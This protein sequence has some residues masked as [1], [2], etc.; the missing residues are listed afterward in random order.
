VCARVWSPMPQRPRPAMS[1]VEASDATA[2]PHG[3][4]PVLVS[5]VIPTYN[6]AA[7]VTEQ[8]RALRAQDYDGPVE[9]I[10]ADNGSTDDLP[11]VVAGAREQGMRIRIADASDRRG[12]SHARNVGCREAAG[13]LI[14]I[15]DAD[16]VVDSGWLSALVVTAQ[17]AAV[18]GGSIDGAL[19][20][21]SSVQQWRKAY[22]P[23]RLPVKLGFLPYAVG[24]NL[25]VWTEVVDAVAGWDE[26]LVGG[27]D[28]VD[29]SWRVQLAG[30]PLAVAPRA[31]VRYRHRERL[32]GLG[33]QMYGY[34]LTDVLLYR[35]YR[36][37]G[38]RRR[39]PTMVVRDVYWLAARLPRL[40]WSSAERGIWIN[41]AAQ[42]GGR[43]RGSLRYRVWFI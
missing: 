30:Y 28:D 10:V 32:A 43:I 19:L 25:A 24:C 11:V 35:K 31:I 27:G 39:P 16:D 21:G 40:A 2:W 3:R 22:D 18:V 41:R 12:V 36:H 7:T 4:L 8:L 14:A 42:L 15:C 9:I 17:H 26:G 13:D 6:A 20:N 1:P 38:A 23:Q 29:F 5:V 33:R 34:A 37:E